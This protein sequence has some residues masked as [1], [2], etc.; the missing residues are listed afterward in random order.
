M[1]LREFHL[2]SSLHCIYPGQAGTWDPLLQS[3]YLEEHHFQ[4]QNTKKLERT[5]N[6]CLCAVGAN[7]EQEETKC[8]KPQ[9]P[10]FLATRMA[11]GSSWARDLNSDTVGTQTTA[12]T[13][14]DPK[15]AVPPRTPQM[16]LRRYRE[17]EQ[18]T[19]HA[20]CTQ[21]HQ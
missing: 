16:P 18:G 7:Y 8:S 11:Y 10:L 17:Q 12:V 15:S 20:P 21:D 14:L 6:N 9:L 3:L 13:T 2:Q 19:L 5:K 4:Q 1:K